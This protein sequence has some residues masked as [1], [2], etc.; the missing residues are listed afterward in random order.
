LFAAQPRL[1]RAD[2]QHTAVRR[3]VRHR[4]E[5]APVDAADGDAHLLGL[6]E[7]VLDLFRVRIVPHEHDFEPPLP[8]LQRGEDGLPAFHVFHRRQV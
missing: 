4:V 2:R 7:H 5:L 8:S 6:R 1:L 3:P